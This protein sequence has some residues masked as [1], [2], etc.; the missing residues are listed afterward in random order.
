V[1]RVYDEAGNMIET[2]EQVGKFKEPRAV[3]GPADSERSGG[4]ANGENPLRN[5][6]A[7]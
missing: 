6:S 2:H 4:I 7:S 5:D 3:Q 1:I